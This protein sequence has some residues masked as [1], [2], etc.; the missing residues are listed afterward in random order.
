MRRQE[1]TQ[2]TVHRVARATPSLE[3]DRN[4]N[5]PRNQ[6]L[7]ELLFDAPPTSGND[8][9]VNTSLAESTFATSSTRT[10]C[11]LCC[12]MPNKYA[13]DKPRTR[14]GGGTI[15]AASTVTTSVTA[16]TIAASQ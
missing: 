10:T 5:L 16:S 13:P 6:S 7:T 4:L 1:R 2:A 9:S 11:S 12:T 8:S 14:V 3:R 15:F